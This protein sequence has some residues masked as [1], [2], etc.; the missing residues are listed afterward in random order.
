VSQNLWAQKV[1][2]NW[3]R[4]FSFLQLSLVMLQIAVSV[5]LI[6]CLVSSDIYHHIK[7]NGLWF[8]WI[9]LFM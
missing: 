2:F 6:F 1:N 8:I 9:T 4:S 7:D 3:V 5:F